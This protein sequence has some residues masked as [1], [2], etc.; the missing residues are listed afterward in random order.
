[1]DLLGCHKRERFKEYIA[2]PSKSRSFFLFH[3]D[4][5]MA[6]LVSIAVDSDKASLLIIGKTLSSLRDSS[7]L[8]GLSV[9]CRAMVTRQSVSQ[10]YKMLK[11]M[12]DN[13]KA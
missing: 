13:C 12:Q 5:R 2:F 6:D 9:P 4:L 7:D 8:Q 1:M 3:H 10:D 11:K